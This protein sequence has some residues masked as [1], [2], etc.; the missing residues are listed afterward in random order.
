MTMLPDAEKIADHIRDALDHV[1]E[2][3]QASHLP[4]AGWFPPSRVR[5]PNDFPVWNATQRE[6]HRHVQAGSG[7]SISPHFFMTWNDLNPNVSLS[8]QWQ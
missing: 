4:V 6:S 8:R 2:Q 1:N 5:L 7:C 3:N